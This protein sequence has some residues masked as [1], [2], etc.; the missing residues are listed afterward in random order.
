M[1]TVVVDG[2]FFQL[3][4]SGIARVWHSVLSIWAQNNRFYK[5]YLLD[6]G[7]AP[8]I[9]GIENVPF[10]TY[11]APEAAA[12]SALLEKM[13]SHLGADVFTSTYYTSPMMY[14]MA[15]MVYDMIPELFDFDMNIK[16][17]MEKET[18]IA[19][20]QRYVCI[21]ESTRRDLLKLYPEIPE[22]S[23]TVAYCGVDTNSFDKRPKRAV[24]TFK[25][26]HDL[27]RDYFLFVG[28]RVQHKAYKNSDLFFDALQKMKDVDFDVFC[29]GGEP[30]IE[31][32][33][34]DKLPKGV[35]CRRV[36]LTDHELSLAYAGAVALVY[37][38][39]YEGFGM[40]VIEAMAS[41][42]PVITTHHGSLA[43][44]AG[45]SAYLISGHSV[46]EMVEALTRLQDPAVREDLHKRGLQHAAKFRWE[47]IA[48]EMAVQL[49]NA[50]KQK[51]SPEFRKFAG[52]WA[53]LRG[54][55]A[56][57]DHQ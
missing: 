55:Q 2:V 54:L 19:F 44:A 25:K 7:N 16:D 30:E 13:C 26:K 42:C 48:E 37:P 12:D 15:L 39:L 3:A 50:I 9:E 22:S 10:P 33:V 40:P 43:E 17:W 20:A 56:E 24:N 53:R 21:S 1:T 27:K 11:H 23:V 14:P 36:V 52:E 5:V 28:S 18:A 4:S 38:S 46:D 41:G 45:D 49:E 29:V 8:T 31:Q 32:S 57:V 47:P 35:D 51:D 6:R 34:L